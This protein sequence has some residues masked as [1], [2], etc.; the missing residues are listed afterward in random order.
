MISLRWLLLPA[1]VCGLTLWHCPTASADDVGASSVAIPRGTIVPILVTKD[2]RVG[3]YGAS[4]EEHKMRFT[5]AQ[6]VV[7]SGY[8]VARQGDVADGHFDTQT[9][10]T[11]RVFSTNTS[12]ELAVDVDDV[13]NFCGDTIHLVFERTYVGGA[14]AGTMSFGWHS[15]DAVFAKGSVLKAS[16]DRREKGICADKTTQSPLPL[17]AGIIVPDDEVS[18]APPDGSRS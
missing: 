5:V 10:V 4:Q 18:P 9:N 15:H 11:K 12:V 13:V 17:P 6:D 7:V 3:G 16:T 2:I 8:V 1:L 14:R